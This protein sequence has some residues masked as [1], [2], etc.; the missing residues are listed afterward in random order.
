MSAEQTAV[1][2]ESGTPPPEPAP[3]PAGAASDAVASG[4]GA[5]LQAAREAR[6]LG[7]QQVT[8][9][10]HIEPRLV[11]AMEADDFG[12]FDAPVYAR[13]FL[14][15][16]AA[17]LEVPADEIVA[18]YERL[19]AGSGAPS[20]IPP[21]SAEQPR[22]D[23]SVLKV[24][25]VI[26]GVL[27]LVGGS[28]W[29]WLTRAPAPDAEPSR[30]AV[31]APTPSPSATTPGT[32]AAPAPDAAVPSAAIGASAPSGAAVGALSAAAPPPALPSGAALEI[33]FLGDCWVEVT[34]RS[35]ERL[36]YDLGVA[37][38]S[39]A[40]PGPGPWRVFLG[41]ADSARLRVAGRPVPIPAASRS[42]ATARLVVGPDGTVQ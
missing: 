24:P 1:G 30:P 33:D 39:R 8:D 23:W 19:H 35:G 4:P 13:G 26:A 31:S 5:R 2:A 3:A 15:K 41:A 18:D 38:E 17:F 27:L 34:G 22:R 25:L 36:M 21:A 28:Y 16:Y 9:L 37:G 12:A 42:G 20:L 29:W 10:L 40:L 32:A 6:Q 14:R 7:I 11:V